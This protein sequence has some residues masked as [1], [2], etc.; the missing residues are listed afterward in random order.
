MKKIL[1]VL[2]LAILTVSSVS[3]IQLLTLY[4]EVHN[5]TGV[6]DGSEV[7]V[8]P[9]D[10]KSTYIT[11]I[12]GPGG[13]FNVTGYWKVNLFNLPAHIGDGDPVYIYVDDGNGNS[14]DQIWY[15][16]MS[17]GNNRVADMTLSRALFDVYTF[18]NTITC[19]DYT[20][21]EDTS[22]G[23]ALYFYGAWVLKDP[24]GDVRDEKLPTQIHSDTY[25]STLTYTLDEA[26]DWTF[27]MTIMYAETE[28]NPTTGVWDVID[29]GVCVNHIRDYSVLVPEPNFT[30]IMNMIMQ[31]YQ[32]WLNSL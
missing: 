22:D 14:D 12:V 8:G 15:V 13:K 7:K 32:N 19:T 18:E 9:L 10:D 29:S 24:S 20:L 17:K 27:Y 23:D 31:V 21:D 6:A 4:G 5:G 16:D 2:L 30:S 11:D 3:A 26:G 28:Y 25:T 1:T